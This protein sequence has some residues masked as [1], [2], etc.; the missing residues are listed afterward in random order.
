MKNT[1]DNTDLNELQVSILGSGR[2]KYATASCPYCFLDFSVDIDKSET[3]AINEVRRK[4]KEHI[5]ICPL[6]CKTSI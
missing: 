6:A 2:N 4:C 3:V 1:S 5:K